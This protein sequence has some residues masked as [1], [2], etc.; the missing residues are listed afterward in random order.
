MPK[1]ASDE[2]RR[3]WHDVVERQKTSGLNIAQF[4]A[5]AGV[6]QNSFYVWK[7][8]LRIIDSTSERSAPRP[9]TASPRRKRRGKKPMAKSMSLVPVRLVADMNCESL[10]AGVIEIAWP[11]GIVLRI[12]AGC[13]SDTLRDVFGL[14]TTA[15]NGAAPSC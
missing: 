14:L 7:R 3:F 10:P 11:E 13:N 9:S 5:Q 2:R 6:A 4:C 1:K 8:R 12:P 15:M